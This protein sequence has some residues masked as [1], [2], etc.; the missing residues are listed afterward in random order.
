VSTK[1]APR[2]CPAANLIYLVIAKK[3]ETATEQKPALVCRQHRLRIRILRILKIPQIHE[4]L[5]ILKMPINFTTKIHSVEN[6]CY[7]KLELSTANLQA[8]LIRTEHH[9]F[10][11]LAE[12]K[13]R[14][15]SKLSQSSAPAL[16]CTDTRTVVFSSV[17]SF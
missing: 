5:R 15:N 12:A 11:P 8:K 17:V 13:L 14:T 16:Q 3:Q 2:C 1:S 9:I 6:K 7:R 4:F 10:A